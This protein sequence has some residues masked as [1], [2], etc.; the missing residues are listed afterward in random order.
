MRADSEKLA[1]LAIVGV[2]AAFLMLKLTGVSITGQYSAKV[3]A[4]A[5]AI[6]V[7]EGFLNPDGSKKSAGTIP[8]DRHNPGDITSLSGGVKTFATDDEG[9]TALYNYVQRMIDGTGHYNT[10]MTWAE[11]GQ[12]YD[13]EAAYMNWVNNVTIA[14][15]VDPNSTL[16]DFVN[17]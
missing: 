12:I 10:S 4:I 17:A 15:A 2:G 9:W 7:A 11:I 3:V 8:V 14:L 13:G 5:R 1:V 16:G 6:A